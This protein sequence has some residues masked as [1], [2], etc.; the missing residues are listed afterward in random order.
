MRNNVEQEA[1]M[2]AQD[3]EQASNADLEK[4]KEQCEQS[5]ANVRKEHTELLKWVTFSIF[6]PFQLF[7]SE[8]NDNCLSPGKR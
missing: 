3:T 8:N 1:V 7:Q 4:A 5:L 2:Y 6:L